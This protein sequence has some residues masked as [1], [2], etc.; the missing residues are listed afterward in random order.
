M[1]ILSDYLHDFLALFFPELCA[2][3]GTGL[4]KNEE[5]ICT[6]C[7]YNLPV[8]N[9][10]K[11]PESKLARQLWGRLLCRQAGAFVYFR[12]GGR[13]QNII[14]QLKYNKRPEAGFRMGQLYANTLNTSLRWVRPDLIIPVPLHPRK[15]RE[16]GYNQSE[17]FANGMASVFRIPVMNGNL[18]RKE[19]TETQTSKSRYSRYENLRSA[20]L[21]LDPGSLISKHILL[22]D[23]VMTTGA[24]L[25]ACAAALPANTELSIVA[26]AYTE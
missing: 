14:H 22:V 5:V 8:T 19:N 15:L 11:D 13:V 7:I 3:C 2:A 24:T 25:E 21:C 23:D 17:H 6:G 26:I 20:F 4:L 12:K 10:H 18:I 9:F 1:A 16:R